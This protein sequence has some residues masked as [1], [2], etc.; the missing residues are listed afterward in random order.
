MVGYVLQPITTQHAVI[1]T[2]PPPPP[3]K[4]IQRHTIIRS[5]ADTLNVLL[6]LNNGLACL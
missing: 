1:Y 5:S 6:G 3:A 2:L 4:C